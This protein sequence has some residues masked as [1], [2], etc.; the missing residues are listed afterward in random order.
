VNSS[1]MVNMINDYGI[2]QGKMF[3]LWLDTT[4]KNTGERL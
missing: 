2:T 3:S 4:K 1:M